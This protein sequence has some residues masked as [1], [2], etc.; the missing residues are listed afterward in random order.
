ME[1]KELEIESHPWQP[2]IPDGAKV[3]IMGT[4]PP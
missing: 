2:F 3:L 4:F 1:N